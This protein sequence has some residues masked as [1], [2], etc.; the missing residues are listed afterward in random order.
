VI[1]NIT[2][3]TVV[4]LALIVIYLLVQVIRMRR[5]ID[6][7]PEE[8]GVFEALQGLDA[9]LGTVEETVAD[10][11]PRMQSVEGRL[12]LALSRTGVVV[13]DAF[14]D[15]AG[16]LS[17]SIAL[18]NERGDGIVISMLVGRSEARFFTKMVRS[19]T[20]T[21]PFS[22]EEEAAIREARSG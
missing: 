14:D 16:R 11:V 3:G 4:V 1:E 7:V 6:L 22:P 9:D 17:R 20:G 13:Y 8:G 5:K 19:G 21:E 18:L 12:P 10:L 15:I 2:L